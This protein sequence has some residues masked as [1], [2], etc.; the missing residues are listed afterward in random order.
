M[1][2]QNGSTS[3]TFFRHPLLLLVV[4]SVIGSILIPYFSEA[5]TKK[6]VLQEARLRK[7]VDIVDTNTRTVS[8]LNS[9]ATR[10]AMFHERNQRLKPTP[11]QLRA[12]QDKLIE[13]MDARYL[14]FEKL[15]W[16]WYRDLNDEAVILN[17]VPANGS[18][19]LRAHI[20]SYGQ[21]ML[22]TTN[23]LK[24]MWHPCTSADYDYKG[25]KGEEIS[26]IKKQMDTKLQDLFNARNGIVYQLVSDFTVKE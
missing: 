17:I 10:V 2:P 26:E 5:A 24:T 13:D 3:F 12:L 15:G 9:L 4:G 22:D 7:A 20:N 23:A 19:A 1:S 25:K 8:Q 16:W 14:E 6:K 21:N 11:A 18:D